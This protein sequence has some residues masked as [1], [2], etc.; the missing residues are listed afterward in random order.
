L[1]DTDL[2]IEPVPPLNGSSEA[3]SIGQ[4]NIQTL[5]TDADR[6]VRRIAYE[7]YADAHLAYRNTMAA[8]LATEVK[9]NVF[10]ARARYFD[11]AL[12][13]AVESDFVPESVFHNLITTYRKHLPTWHRYWRV[14]RQALGYETLYE[15]DV[16][17]PLTDTPPVISFSQAL[18][19]VC[20]GMQP[21]GDEYVSIMRRGAETERWIDI[22]PSVGKR[23]GAF[24]SG[25]PGTH[26]FI[27]LNNNDD[28]FGLSTL[29]HELGHSMHSYYSW[30]NQPYIY[31]DYP[32]FLAEVA[33]N[34][35][36]ALVRDYLFR[37]T[38]ALDFQIALIEEAMSNFHRYF[39]IMPTLAR[40]EAEIHR[41]VEEGQSLTANAMIA[42]MAD[43]FREGYGDEV[44]IDDVRTGITWAQFSTQM[45]LNFYV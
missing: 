21:L 19:W 32:I 34:F 13:A 22:Y 26:P 15:Y 6:E 38:D 1:T 35:N 43:L 11:S 42:L 23:A 27:M 28:I 10:M 12:Q 7:H 16:K 39:F 14:R 20:T 33:S 40:F 17:A 30:Q 37:T 9:E 41:Q 44:E 24:S 4:G 45:Y 5:L 18:E 29:A 3:I 31:A 8:S 25:A 2:V 36:Q